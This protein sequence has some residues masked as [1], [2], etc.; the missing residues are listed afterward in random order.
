MEIFYILVIFQLPTTA[1]VERPTADTTPA[2]LVKRPK[3]TLS[4]VHMMACVLKWFTI[5]IL[6]L[7][8]L[9][10]KRS[11]FGGKHVESAKP[12]LNVGRK[13]HVSNE[14][15]CDKKKFQ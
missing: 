1:P 15:L 14:F 5:V 6:I 2:S 8:S 11:R 4:S 3:L 7:L 9:K 12:N 13:A 10:F